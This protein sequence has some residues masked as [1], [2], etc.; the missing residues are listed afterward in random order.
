[1]KNKLFLLFGV[2]FLIGFVLVGC[3]TDINNENNAVFTGEFWYINEDG[4][5][6]TTTLTIDNRSFGFYFESEQ[7]GT[8]AYILQNPVW[9]AILLPDKGMTSYNE[10]DLSYYK[11]NYPTGYSIT[12]IVKKTEGDWPDHG[13][14]MTEYVFLHKDDPSKLLWWNIGNSP[15]ILDKKP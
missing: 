8:F 3:D 13:S 11:I 9:V 1:M 10:Y 7:Y 5:H 12:G 6:T 14:Q 2:L 4:D 15:I